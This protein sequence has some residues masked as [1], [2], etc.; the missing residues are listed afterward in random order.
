M[1]ALAI[2]L[3]PENIRVKALC[4]DP[5]DTPMLLVFVKR[6]DQPGTEDLDVEELIYK[7]QSRVPMG[8]PA[9]P[10]EI[11]NAALFLLWEEASYVIG[12]AF[13]VDGGVT[14]G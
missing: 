5:T 2:R 13:S 12:V 9:K 6:P 14:A 7:R 3:A 10:E 1:K 11:A 4:P 8:R